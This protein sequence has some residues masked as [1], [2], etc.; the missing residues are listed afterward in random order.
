MS[1]KKDF[2]NES[3]KAYLHPIAQDVIQEFLGN[4]GKSDADAVVRY[5]IRKVCGYVAQIARAQALGLDP[6][7][8][9][10]S[11]EE[12]AEHM[13]MVLKIALD[14]GKPVIV[15]EGAEAQP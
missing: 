7:V 12:A 4:I 14:V 3:E 11:D 13:A 10:L 6:E 8:L 1:W 2:A 5:G 9:R 15:V